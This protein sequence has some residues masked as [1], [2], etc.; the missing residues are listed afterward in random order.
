M[1]RTDYLSY[2]RLIRALVCVKDATNNLQA[3]DIHNDE[4]GDY[5]F[6]DDDHVENANTNIQRFIYLQ[7]LETELQTFKKRFYIQFCTLCAYWY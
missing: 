6:N 2:V 3:V 1:C 5:R 4:V 7:I